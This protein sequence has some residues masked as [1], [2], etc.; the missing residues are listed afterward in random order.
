[1][2]ADLEATLDF[3]ATKD[4]NTSAP[5]K[6]ATNMRRGSKARYF[7]YGRQYGDPFRH[8]NGRKQI[9]HGSPLARRLQPLIRGTGTPILAVESI[10]DEG[11]KFGLAAWRRSPAHQH[12]R[13]YRRGST[14]T[15]AS[16]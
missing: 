13:I 9:R 12:N 5:S 11:G 1:M 10:H 8:N 2:Q 6:R 3:R 15:F 4:V 14:C 16:I 7:P